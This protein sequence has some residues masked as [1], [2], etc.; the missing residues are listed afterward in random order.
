MKIILKFKLLEFTL[1]VMFL[2]IAI[3]VL[4]ARWIGFIILG[5]VG[6]M[7]LSTT[8]FNKIME[9]Y[10]AYCDH[11]WKSHPNGIATPLICVRCNMMHPDEE[12]ETW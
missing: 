7:F 4:E 10:P 9:Y 6:A 3:T 2:L 8:L 12:P 5:A 11:L 1:D